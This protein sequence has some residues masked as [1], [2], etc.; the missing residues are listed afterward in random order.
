MHLYFYGFSAL[1][2]SNTNQKLRLSSSSL[3]LKLSRSSLY[4]LQLPRQ[5][6]ARVRVVKHLIIKRDLHPAAQP[7]IQR[8]HPRNVRPAVR[9]PL[10][11]KPRVTAPFA[12][13]LPIEA[14]L[15]RVWRTHILFPSPRRRSYPVAIT[16]T[17]A[18]RPT[19]CTWS[20]RS[21]LQTECRLPST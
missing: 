17:P 16:I 3:I 1:S 21:R 13:K 15:H 8:P 5:R 4:P 9:V 10:R 19:S 6:Y 18:G 7:I 14:L 12:W 2:E 20:R 11:S